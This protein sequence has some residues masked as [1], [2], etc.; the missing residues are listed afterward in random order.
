MNPANLQCLD[1]TL[2]K[3]GRIYIKGLHLCCFERV[4]YLIINELN[5]VQPSQKGCTFP[6]VVICCVIY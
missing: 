1:Y 4:F 3:S 5:V 6:V 2:K